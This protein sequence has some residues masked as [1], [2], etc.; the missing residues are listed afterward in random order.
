[1]AE[2]SVLK[3]RQSVLQKPRGQSVLK[4]G[5]D[6]VFVI[7]RSGS[8]KSC[9]EGV[10]SWIASFVQGVKSDPK[11]NVD[12]RF[13]FLGYDRKELCRMKEF[14]TGSAERFASA[15][16]SIGTSGANEI[17]LPAIDQ[18]CG[19][20]WRDGVHRFLVVLTDEATDTGWEP[21]WQ[22]EKAP[23]LKQKLLAL[24][25]KLRLIAPACETFRTFEGLPHFEYTQADGDAALEDGKV[26][27]GLM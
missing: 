16:T 15:L 1:V 27:A 5:A 11:V 21:D 6:V 8:M 23:Q 25:I 17:T 2:Q 22:R 10:T 14:F 13:G 18:A 7:D 9:F 3:P 19:F 4:G 12:L 20:P 24:R 26:L